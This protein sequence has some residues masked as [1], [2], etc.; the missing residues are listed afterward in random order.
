MYSSKRRHGFTLVELLV[1]IAI[2]GILIA[3]LLPAVQAAREAARRSQCTNNLKQIG[4]AIQNYH[5]TR[6]EI[7]PRYL[8]WDPGNGTDTL[9]YASWS[10][11]LLP[12]L[13][14]ENVYELFNVGTRID[15]NPVGFNH[16]L[17][18]I[19]A[20]PTYY[21][22]TRRSPPQFT[23]AAGVNNASVGD[24]AAVSFAEGR[25]AVNSTVNLALPLTYDG[26]I[27]ASKA[28]NNTATQAT[29]NGVFL[30]AGEFKSF[31]NFASVLDGLSNTALI[32]E[33]AVHQSRL[34]NNSTQPCAQPSNHFSPPC[35][36]GTFY[37]ATAL[38]F[39]A[40]RANPGPTAFFSRRLSIDPLN[41]TEPVILRQP[42]LD[43]PRN[44]FGGW[45]TGVTL[46]VL[47]DGS[48]RPVSNATSSTTLVRLGGRND[49]LTLTLP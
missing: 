45:H 39:T 23:T 20:I 46:F 31:T 14:Q 44:R 37:F 2:I 7:V 9:G 35:Q 17:G 26:T 43:D 18:R 38:G 11:L 32:G 6:K 24:Y 29:F 12:Y 42:T 30:G 22:P 47:G 25:G 27:V 41:P 36:D 49:G 28:F 3:L 19:T 34:G 21:C 5:D 4:V 48:V 10:V 16:P 15:T 1:V 13:E 33:K 40:T 8:S